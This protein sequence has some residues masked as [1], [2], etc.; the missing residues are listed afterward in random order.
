M[1]QD[2][3]QSA[4]WKQHQVSLFTAALWFSGELHP[5]V[6]ASDNLDHGKDTIIAYI[7]N[8]LDSL[9]GTVKTISIWSDG[10][11]SQFKNRFIVAAISPLQEKHKVT[12]KWNFFATSH[13]KGQST[14]LEAQSKDKCGPQSALERLLSQMQPHFM[15]LQ[16]SCP[17][18]TS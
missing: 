14:A 4:H 16:S 12:I 5:K 3:I 17:I 1:F 13:G 15:Q 8:I 9:P 7:D 18:S 11:S 6:I 10:P 2:E